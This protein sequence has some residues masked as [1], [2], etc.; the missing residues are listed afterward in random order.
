M[1]S[2]LLV[3]LLFLFTRNCVP[4]G[5][6]AA[7]SPQVS[8]LKVTRVFRTLRFMRITSL[9]VS[10][11][12]TTCV[13]PL[14][15]GW[16]HLKPKLVLPQMTALCIIY[17]ALNFCQSSQKTVCN[18]TTVIVRVVCTPGHIYCMCTVTDLHLFC[19]QCEPIKTLHKTRL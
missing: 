5:F 8:A 15:R 18:N 19:R 4:Y 6:S 12:I 16:S 7:L 11:Y 1:P 14:C 13:L 10:D 2:L 3:D 17:R 9:Y